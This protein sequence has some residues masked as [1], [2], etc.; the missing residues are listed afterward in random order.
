MEVQ[1][2]LVHEIDHPINTVFV[3]IA[4]GYKFD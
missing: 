2:D 1:E 3:M 4:G